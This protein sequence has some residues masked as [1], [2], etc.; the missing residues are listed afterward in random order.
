[1]LQYMTPIMQ[2][3]W[4]VFVTQE[5]MPTERWIGFII[6]WVAVIIYLADLVRM[7]RASR[8]HARLHPAPDHTPS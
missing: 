7:G 2:M 6:I 1:M 4:A 5:H 8:R 3:L